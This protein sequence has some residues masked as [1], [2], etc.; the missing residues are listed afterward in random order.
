MLSLTYTCM[1]HD[2]SIWLDIKDPAD[3]R[4]RFYNTGKLI[5]NEFSI[6]SSNVPIFSLY[7]VFR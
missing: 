7:G 3:I 4:L 1:S 5:T 2:L 6:L